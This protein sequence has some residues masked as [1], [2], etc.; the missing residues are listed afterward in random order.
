MRV[1]YVYDGNWPRG[2]T[3]VAKQTRSLAAAGHT[4]RL[5][6]RNTHREPRRESTG[7]M[8]VI[9]LPSVPI[10]FLNRLINFPLFV[11]PFWLWTIYRAARDL[12][13]ECLVVC[14][15]PLALTA[16]W[17][18]RWLR[19]PVHYDMAEVYP[20]FLRSLWAVD[21]MGWRDR[22]VRNPRAAEW[23]ERWVLARADTVFVVSEESRAR[24]LGL[25]V[26]EERVVIVGNTPENVE[27]LSAPVPPPEDLRPWQGRPIV[28]FVGILIADRGVQLSVEAMPLVLQ[29]VPDAVLV[30][31]GDG[32][33]KPAIEAAVQRLGIQA[34]VA[35]LGWRAHEALAGYYQ[36][37]QVGLLPFLDCT[38]I[39]ITLANKLFDYMAAGLA[40]V[41]V[42]VPPMRRI[43]EECE[44]GLLFPPSDV[45]ALAQRITR[46]LLDP[47]LRRSCGQ[48]GEVAVAE[49]YC[50]SVDAE[51]F[52]SAVTNGS[53][54]QE[55]SAG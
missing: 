35:V 19:V 10:A 2:A 44:S 12:R 13:A 6:A 5:V 17:V 18:G 26:P 11:S 55:V 34:H 21:V 40:V 14:D 50:W 33:E 52:V 51:R 48:R 7:W 25:G 53:P 38:H 37:A 29:E 54:R 49:K 3:R 36:H 24:C 31:V 32:P 30:V 23:I 15:L 8:T 16:L 9:R 4:V 39:R 22:I 27:I 47:E 46:L 1:L 43:I 20:E 28:L 42:Y 41:A 45:G